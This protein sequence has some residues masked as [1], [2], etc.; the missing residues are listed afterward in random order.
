MWFGHVQ[1]E[2]FLHQL[3]ARGGWE[4]GSEGPHSLASIQTLQV[5]KVSAAEALRAERLEVG[6]QWS[7]LVCVKL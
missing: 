5:Y 2:L 3:Q 6:G 4:D 7:V 1:L